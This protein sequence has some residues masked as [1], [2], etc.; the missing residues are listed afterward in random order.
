MAQGTYYFDQTVRGLFFVNGLYLSAGPFN[1]SANVPIVYQNSPYVPY[2]GIGALPTGGSE[3]PIVGS[4][5]GR[6]PGSDPIIL[7]ESET[8]D[9][10]RLGLADPFFRMGIRLWKESRYV[11]SVEISV[12][13]KVPVATFES[14]FGTG[15]WDYAAGVSV[16]K[17]LGRVVLLAD[18]GYWILGDLPELDLKD[19]WSYIASLGIPLAGG[20][21]ALMLSYFGFSR[22]I[23]GVEP[24]RSLG[25]GLSFKVGPKSS[26]LLNGSIG[27]S[28]F[29]SDFSASL[30][31]SIGL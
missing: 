31:W 18:I 8:V 11:P 9:Y 20:K 28:E 15:K 25:L 19:P 5:P 12:Q 10:K 22:I 17:R 23:S 24:P 14:G 6:R 3:S 21:T 26:L 29:S 7:P 1:L 13:A 27:L 4:Q 2:S 30:G 16:G